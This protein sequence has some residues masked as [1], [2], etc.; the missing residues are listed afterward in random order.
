MALTASVLMSFYS[1]DQIGASSMRM[2]TGLKYLYRNVWI[3]LAVGS[4]VVES[5]ILQIGTKVLA[6]DQSTAMIDSDTLSL[7]NASNEKIGRAHV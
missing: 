7:L 2:R 5:F 1:F 3:I 6:A 4:L